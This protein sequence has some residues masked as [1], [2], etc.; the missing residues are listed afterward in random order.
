MN[1]LGMVHG[2]GHGEGQRQDPSKIYKIKLWKCYPTE[3]FYPLTFW[4]ILI[5]G[6][7]CKSHTRCDNYI[8]EPQ[9]RLVLAPATIALTNERTSGR[10]TVGLWYNTMHGRVTWFIFTQLNCFVWYVRHDFS[11]PS[12]KGCL[13]VQC[14]YL[15]SPLLVRDVPPWRSQGARA[16]GGEGGGHHPGQ[17]V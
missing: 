8:L 13:R 16:A 7:Y 15:Q 2:Q 14:S 10:A 3:F 9:N 1:L 4:H 11:K 12:Q 6:G 5:N 17:V